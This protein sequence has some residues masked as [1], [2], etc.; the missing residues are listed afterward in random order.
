MM[1]EM[2]GFKAG[3]TVP[4]TGIYKCSFCGM[5]NAFKNMLS[6]K[7]FSME[8]MQKNKPTQKRFKKGKKFKPCPKCKEGTAW[9]WVSS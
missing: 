7:G 6:G 8:E 3:D 5:G 1:S 4:E 2:R 9:D